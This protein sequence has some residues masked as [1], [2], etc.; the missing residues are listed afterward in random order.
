MIFEGDQHPAFDISGR[1]VANA[2]NFLPSDKSFMVFS[3]QNVL[4]SLDPSALVYMF[5]DD[6]IHTIIYSRLSVNFI[7]A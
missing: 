4:F 6:C 5:I 2:T 3:C 7:D 1:T